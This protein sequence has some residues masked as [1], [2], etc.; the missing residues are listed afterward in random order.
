M[1]KE[2][3]KTYF[4]ENAGSWIEDGYVD[5]GYNFPVASH[6]NRI[7]KKAI[8]EHFSDRKINIIDIGCGGGDLL[9]DLKD[10][11][12]EMVGIDQS[13]SMIDIANEKNNQ[14]DSSGIRFFHKDVYHYEKNMT[15][16]VV[17]A[18]GVIGYQENSEFFIKNCVDLL[19]ENGIFLISSRNRLFNLFPIS[20]YMKHEM[21]E[22]TS[23]TL[24]DEISELNFSFSNEEEIHF[25]NALKDNVT[26]LIEEKR[27]GDKI[28]LSK[29]TEEKYTFSCDDG[30]QYTP[31]ALKKMVEPY[32]LTFKATVGVHPHLLPTVL[33]EKFSSGVYNRLN[34][35][36]VAFENSPLSLFWSSLFISIFEKQA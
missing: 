10:H 30:A 28:P 23:E 21:I 35:S 13:Q 15:Y 12:K 4:E 9:F 7:V 14:L 29:K 5:D 25:L 26:R 24:L 3:V 22:N 33:K 17:T 31:L 2:N 16:D 19:K 27:R 1:L 11:G 20:K 32:G 36:L 34:E 6:R 8:I 18:M